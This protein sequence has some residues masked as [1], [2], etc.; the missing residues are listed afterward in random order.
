MNNFE[1]D[2]TPNVEKYLESNYDLPEKS[3]YNTEDEEMLIPASFTAEEKIE[4][5]D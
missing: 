2:K 4:R 3:E 1:K 5:I